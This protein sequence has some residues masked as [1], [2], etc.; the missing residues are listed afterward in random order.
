MPSKKSRDISLRFY[1]LLLIGLLFY[2]AYAVLISNIVYMTA[3]V[4]SLTQGGLMLYFSKKYKKVY[5]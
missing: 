5:E 1:S 3:N 2:M 4:L